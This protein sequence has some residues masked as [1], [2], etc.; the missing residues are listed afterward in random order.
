MPT[1]TANAVWEGGLRTGNGQFS[2]QSGAFQGKY[3]FGTRFG[4]DPGTNPEEL[5]A[6]AHAACISMAL[7]LGL[8]QAGTP[9]TRISTT[10][11]CT[12]EKAGEGFKITR[13]KLEV[14]G[15][16]PGVDAAAFAR[17]A[18]AARDGCP[19]SNALKGNVQIEVDARLA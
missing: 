3:S 8:E 12:V 6:A 16:V 18:E 9:P 15:Q 11:K 5:I 1:S 10:A 13:M 7:A 17:A 2:A 14:R 19:V 4:G